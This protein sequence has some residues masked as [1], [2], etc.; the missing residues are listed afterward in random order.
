L[1]IFLCHMHREVASGHIHDSKE[2]DIK[3][4]LPPSCLKVCAL[5]PKICQWYHLPLHRTTATAV[6]MAAPV[7]KIKDYCSDF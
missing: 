7:P 4:A 1:I 3:S 6:Q 2:K 5:I